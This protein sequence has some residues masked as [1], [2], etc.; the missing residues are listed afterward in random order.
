MLFFMNSLFR[1]GLVLAFVAAT[2]TNAQD[3]TPAREADVGAPAGPAGPGSQPGNPEPDQPPATTS[4]PGL[5]SE[6]FTVPPGRYYPEGTFLVRRTGTIRTLKTGEVLFIPDKPAHRDSRRRGERP[7]MLLPCQTLAAMQSSVNGSPDPLQTR[8]EVSGQLF[9][10]RDRQHLLPTVFSALP[11]PPD[12]K[13]VAKPKPAAEEPASSV[14]PTDDPEVSDMITALE[15][16]RQETQSLPKTGAAPDAD[17]QAA[18]SLVPEGTLITD[19][20]GRLTRVKDKLAIAF[21][22]DANTRS[23][24]AMIVIPSR[25]LERL[26]ASLG[27]TNDGVVIVMTGRVFAYRN[28]NYILPLLAQIEA[29][30][31]LKPMQ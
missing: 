24:P 29:D 18:K 3:V 7:M 19:R 13:P 22:G 1:L 4:I 20:R 2:A 17:E 5:T 12:V 28:Q 11:T 9:V 6:T 21:D 26:E 14:Q 31:Q 15:A 30:G 10:Y 16:R 27:P 23:D 25:A 8:V